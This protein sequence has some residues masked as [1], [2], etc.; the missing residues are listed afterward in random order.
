M[1][2][3]RNE[4]YFKQACKNADAIYP[5]QRQDV[6][7]DVYQEFANAIIEQAAIDYYNICAGFDKS[8]SKRSLEDFF[9]S[10]WFS[11]LT[12]MDPEYLIKKIRERADSMI[13]TFT[14]EKERGS[15]RYYVCKAGEKTPLT[16]TY[17]TKKKALHKAAEMQDLTYTEYMRI[18]RRDG[19]DNA[20]NRA[21]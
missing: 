7:M 18:R 5:A 13:L 2:T 16:R 17:S 12:D 14:V 1:I 6:T 20:D 19:V 15:S 10:E 11:I 21:D 9:H 4:A 8:H 3:I